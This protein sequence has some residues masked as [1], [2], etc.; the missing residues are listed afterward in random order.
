MKTRLQFLLAVVIFLIDLAQS[1]GQ[2][3]AFTYQ[4]HLNDNGGVANGSFDLRFGIFDA[5]NSN[6]Q[7]GPLLTNSN[8]RQSGC[9]FNHSS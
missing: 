7:I 2:G 1:Y 8:Q 6:N 9:D 4:G 3:T 5:P